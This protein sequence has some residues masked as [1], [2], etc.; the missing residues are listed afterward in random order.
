MNN[1]YFDVI[2]NRFPSLA[3]STRELISDKLISP[4][5]VRIHKKYLDEAKAVVANLYQLRE[6][7][8][9]LRGVQSKAPE[10]AQWDPKNKSICMSYDFHLDSQ[11]R[12]KLIEVN[13]N[14]A[15]L[16]MGYFLYDLHQLP[17]PVSSFDLNTFNDSCREEAR[18]S[19]NK[20]NSVAIVDEAPSSQRLFIEFLLYEQL[21]KELGY[22]AHIADPAELSFSG[23]AL[24][25]ANGSIDFVYNRTTDFYFD[26][27]NMVALKQAYLKKAITLSPN[28]H[29]YALLADKHRLIEWSLNLKEDTSFSELK[30]IA[31]NLL[32]ADYVLDRNSDELWA[33]KKKVFF[34]PLTSFGSKGTYRGEGISRPY[35]DQLINKDYIAQE[36]CPPR[37]HLFEATGFPTTKLKFDLRFYAYKDQLQMVVARLYQGQ[38]TNLKTTHG[39]FAPVIFE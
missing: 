39:G 5:V 18:L 22:T 34:K 3:D 19:G 2:K 11:D 14:A 29:E 12:L 21:F 27:P 20:L 10:L 4:Y 33:K 23:E 8:N 24:Q 32:E 28:P 9:Y 15:F 36:Y 1:K 38:V 13:T 35:F 31:H 30:A 6:N 16:L 26:Q 25:G 17:R 37:E 7:P